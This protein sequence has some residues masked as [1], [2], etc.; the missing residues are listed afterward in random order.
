[1]PKKP[2]KPKRPRN[3]HAINAHGRNN[4]GAHK[5]RKKAKDKYKCREPKQKQ[6]DDSI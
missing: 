2:K 4:Q 5:D 3:Y 6:N 1:M